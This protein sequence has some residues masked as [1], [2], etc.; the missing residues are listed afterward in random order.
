[1]D[2]SPPSAQGKKTAEAI[3]Q[4]IAREVD[5]L[6][7]IVVF[8]GRRKSAILELGPTEMTVRS[9]HASGRG[10]D[11]DQAAGICG[12]GRRSADRPL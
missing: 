10:N 4:E 5:Q 8:N 2:L 9:R 7:R 3:Q 12:P 11:S 1:M 6:L